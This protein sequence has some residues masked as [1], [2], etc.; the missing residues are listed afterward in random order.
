MKF[1]IIVTFLTCVHR[2]VTAEPGDSVFS[3][4]Q[5]ITMNSV[6]RTT[7]QVE[8]RALKF[9][10]GYLY[11]GGNFDQIGGVKARGIARFNG[12]VWEPVGGG[13]HSGR[14]VSAFAIDSSGRLFAG[15]SFDSIGSAKCSNIALW[16]GVNWLAYGKGEVPIE[17]KTIA[18]DE[19]NI[20]YASGMAYRDYI[21]SRSWDMYLNIYKLENDYWKKHVSSYLRECCSGTFCS[22]PTEYWSINAIVPTV[23][24]GVLYGGNL[25]HLPSNERF[26]NVDAMA[27]DD[28]GNVYIAGDAVYSRGW[29]DYTDTAYGLHKVTKR[30]PAF[31]DTSIVIP[32]INKGG[33]SAYHIYAMVADDKGNLFLAGSWARCVEVWDGKNLYSIPAIVDGIV[34]ALELSPDGKILYVGGK[35]D[36]AGNETSPIIAAVNLYVPV[37]TN[38]LPAPAEIRFDVRVINSKIVLR[39]QPAGARI[40][41]YDLSGQLYRGVCNR[42]TID[43]DKNP[44]QLL[45]IRVTHKGR[46]ATRTVC[47]GGGY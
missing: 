40:S 21:I 11:A 4:P 41:I 38:V 33:S 39:G 5:W 15:G 8:I 23:N 6:A 16:D 24:Y 35:F 25:S 14:F 42:T 46:T 30:S 17:I 9:H 28:S 3:R 29:G 7:N 26:S 1:L 43:L 10:E 2:L 19:K 22:C 45:L 13:I 12:S 44:N 47:I 20:C 34:N 27:L 32:D 31:P 37:K 36:R 18:F